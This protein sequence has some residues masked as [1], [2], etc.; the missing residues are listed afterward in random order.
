[1]IDNDQGRIARGN[2]DEG[3]VVNE[4]GTIDLYFGT[5]LPEGAP[6]TNWV[7]TNEGDGWFVLFRFYGPEKPYYDR[8]FKLNDF[9]RIN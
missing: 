9:E 8:S 2:T 6:A 3:L 4:D 1:M 5:T 7:Q